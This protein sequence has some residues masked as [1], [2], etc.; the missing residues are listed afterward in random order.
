M[1]WYHADKINKK[2]DRQFL[3][4]RAEQIKRMAIAQQE[5][6]MRA[7]AEQ[8]RSQMDEV[9]VPDEGGKILTPSD[10]MPPV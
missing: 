5:H 3:L 7:M 9:A 1:P 4:E 8:Q 2:A 10:F 6:E